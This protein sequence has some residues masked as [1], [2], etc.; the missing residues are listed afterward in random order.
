MLRW[1]LTIFGVLGVIATVFNI[2]VKI[3]GSAEAVTMYAG[4]N[5]NL[6][7]PLIGFIVSLVLLAI[8]KIMDKQDEILDRI[9][10]QKSSQQST[11]R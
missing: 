10:E 4:S 11:H 8:V 6:D 2:A 7:Y 5:R 3:F 9:E 1:T